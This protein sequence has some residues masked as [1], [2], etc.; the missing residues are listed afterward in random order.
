[1]ERERGGPSPHQV[2]EEV[3]KQTHF[4]QMRRDA[5]RYVPLLTNARYER[6]LWEIKTVL[7]INESDDGRPILFQTNVGLRNCH[8]VLGAKID[9]IYDVLEQIDLLLGSNRKVA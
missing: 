3:Q 9:N 2:L 4:E 7:P 6:S 8:C 1:M 5:A